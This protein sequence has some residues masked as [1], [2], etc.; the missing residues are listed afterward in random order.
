MES[1]MMLVNDQEQALRHI[2]SLQHEGFPLSQMYILASDE[3]LVDELVE[4]TG[5]QHP[6]LA[7]EG[8]T[9]ALTKLLRS[10]G[11]RLLDE[12]EALG[13]TQHEAEQYEQALEFGGILI[14]AKPRPESQVY[15]AAQMAPSD[16]RNPPLG[17]N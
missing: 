13:M 7:D 12:M 11:Q 4:I 10:Q 16:Y 3:Q 14:V 8:M 2:Y 15:L 5:A 17:Y 1:R 6:A 9:S